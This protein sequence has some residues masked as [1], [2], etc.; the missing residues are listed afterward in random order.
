MSHG[1]VQFASVG[2]DFT[3]CIGTAAPSD[4]DPSPPPN[5]S[6]AQECRVYGVGGQVAHVLTISH[7]AVGDNFKKSITR[8]YLLDANGKIVRGIDPSWIVTVLFLAYLVIL[9]C[10]LGQTVGYRIL[11]IRLIVA[12]GPSATGVPLSRVIGRYA[13]MLGGFVPGA[14]VAALVLYQALTSADSVAPS[15]MGL[16]IGS[17]LIVGWGLWNLIPIVRKRNPA[18]DRLAGVTVIRV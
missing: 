16:V 4:L 11:R 3:T 17:V 2:A 7:Q 14:I 15:A 6:T 5:P 18:Y 10:R 8:S 13:V 12:V 9:L 1:F